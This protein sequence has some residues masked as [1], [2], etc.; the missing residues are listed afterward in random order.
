M[1]VVSGSLQT[2]TNVAEL[3][4]FKPRL[5]ECFFFFFSW[6]WNSCILNERLSLRKIKK[7]NLYSQLYCMCVPPAVTNTVS[8]S[9]L[10]SQ[11]FYLFLI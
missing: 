3:V 7:L 4:T 5:Q 8:G 6:N 1:D 9:N 2:Q 11:Q 10:H